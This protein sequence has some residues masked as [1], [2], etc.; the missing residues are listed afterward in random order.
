MSTQ[1]YRWT[2]G[3]VT[4]AAMVMF[5]VGF[6]RVLSGISYLADSH[7]V[8]DFSSGFFGDNLWAWGLWDLAIA[9]LALYAGYSLL[10]SGQF[11]RIV[12]YI[13]GVVVIVNSFLIMRIAPWYAAAGIALAALVIYGLSTTNDEPRR[14]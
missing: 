4:F 6:F 12:G 8:N 11:G 10:S 1:E 14:T 5:A 2:S 3:W 13:W 7:K 9:A